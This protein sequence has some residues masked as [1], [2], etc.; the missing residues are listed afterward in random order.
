MYTKAVTIQNPSG[1]HAR[2]AA[3]FVKTAATF[4]AKVH[5]KASGKTG[6]AKSILAVMSLGIAQGTELE[7]TA[8]G[9]DEKAAVEGLAALI[10]SG[11][12]E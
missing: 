6:D 3:Q 4:Q 10:E 5:I 1:L 7:I 11:F 2:P 9:Q 12:G 8:E